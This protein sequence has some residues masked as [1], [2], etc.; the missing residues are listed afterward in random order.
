MTVLR[1]FKCD[2]TGDE[3]AIAWNGTKEVCI[4]EAQAY[5]ILAQEQVQKDSYKLMW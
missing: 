3:L 4:T 5:D 2:L 1:F